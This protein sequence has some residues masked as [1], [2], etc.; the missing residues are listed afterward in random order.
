MDNSSQLSRKFKIFETGYRIWKQEGWKWTW[1]VRLSWWIILVWLYR[2]IIHYLAGLGLS[3]SLT[4]LW[5]ALLI[6]PS[7]SK[8]DNEKLRQSL[9]VIRTQQHGSKEEGR[10][11]LFPGQN[12][13]LRG[14]CEFKMSQKLEK[15]Q[16]GEGISTK[17]QKAHNSDYHLIKTWD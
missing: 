11:H 14:A 2:Q 3:W 15:D 5:T 9:E 10:Y 4:L 6:K 8:T 1:M 17:N 13:K 16:K 12:D 7:Q